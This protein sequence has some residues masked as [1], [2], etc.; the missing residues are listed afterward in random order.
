MHREAVQM[1]LKGFRSFVRKKKR[2]NLA[3]RFIDAIVAYLKGHAV[4]V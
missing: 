4:N 2:I 3:F 1:V